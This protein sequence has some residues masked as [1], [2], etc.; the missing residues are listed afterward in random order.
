MELSLCCT[1]PNPRPLPEQAFNQDCATVQVV[2]LGD[3]SMDL[4]EL[5]MFLAVADKV[6]FTRASE[7]RRAFINVEI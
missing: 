4:R 1:N 6:N 5:E 2:L 7:C 3:F